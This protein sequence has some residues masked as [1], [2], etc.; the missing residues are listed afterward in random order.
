MTAEEQKDFDKGYADAVQKLRD[1]L[2]SRGNPQDKKQSNQDSDDGGDDGQNQGSNNQ[3]QGIGDQSGQGGQQGGQQGDKQSQNGQSN[4]Q[5]D[6]DGE[7]QQGNGDKQGQN[8]GAGNIDKNGKQKAN[9]ESVEGAVD[10]K[11]GKKPGNGKGS[12]G[13]KSGKSGQQGGQQGGPQGKPSIGSEAGKTGHRG[14][15]YTDI[16]KE[17]FTDYMKKI[18]SKH[19]DSAS[20]PISDFVKQC[21]TAAKTK[22][23]IKLKVTE[24]ASWMNKLDREV[25]AYVR[26]MIFKYQQKESTYSRPN[27]RSGVIRPGQPV[28]KGS[29]NKKNTLIIKF[30]FFIDNSG[31]MGEPHKGEPLY[32]AVM[33]ANTIADKTEKSYKSKETVAG[34]IFDFYTFDTVTEKLGRGKM[35]NSGGGTMSFLSLVRDFTKFGSD[36]LVNIVIT[37]AEF[38]SSDWNEKAF[39]DFIKESKGFTV[40]ITN[41]YRDEWVKLSKKHPD[42]KGKFLYIEADASFT[43]K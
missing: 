13:G 12:Q 40:L 34:T 30:A 18:I 17:E 37:D 29:R 11:Y 26:Q 39:L 33:A 4:G 24:G 2:A 9:K 16:S 36:S 35:A 19:K 31:S 14:G 43:N 23:G 28:V 15:V 8:A 10:E 25:D 5:G 6:K 27:R 3:K 1:E 38:D 32:N 42:L 20:S 22:D 21:K 41:G 7:G